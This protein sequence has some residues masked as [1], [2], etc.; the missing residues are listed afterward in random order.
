MLD[1]PGQALSA[2]DKE[3]LEHPLT[4]GLIF[5]TRNFEDH[6]QVTELC[7]EIRSKV[8]K[9]LLFAVDQEGGRVQRFRKDFS[10]LPAMGNIIKHSQDDIGR[11]KQ[12]CQALGELMALEVQSVGIDISFAPVADINNISEVIG[13]RGFANDKATVVTLVEAFCQGMRAAGMATT[14]K[15]FPGHGS[16]REDS[17]IA[18]PVDNREAGDILDTDYWVFEQ[19]MASGALDAVMPAHVIY[20]AFDDL[21]AGFSKV[22]IQQQLRAKL[23][24]SGAVFSDDLTME[25]AV[26]SGSP[27]QRAILAM[28]AGCDMA[29]ICN[30]RDTAIEVLD[31]YKGSATMSPAISN[32]IMQQPTYSGLDTCQASKQWQSLRSKLDELHER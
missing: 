9:P 25:G 19:L 8:N 14:G 17:H 10:A 23:K 27:T 7:R 6:Q 32:M 28:E 16:V 4:G 2:E 5:F 1:L 31:N 29:L 30:N 22:W 20:P 15:H 3:I 24:F 13:D 11:A 26:K 18:L 12:Y 21:P